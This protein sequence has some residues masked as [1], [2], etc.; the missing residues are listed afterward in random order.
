M[1]RGWVYLVFGPI[2]GVIGSLL[3]AI[4]HDGADAALRDPAE[5][6]FLAHAFGFFVSFLALMI[7]AGLARV[8]PIVVRAPLI[9]ATGAAF[10]F[11]CFAV[12]LGQAPPLQRFVLVGVVA[13]GSMGICSLL[14]NDY[15]P[16]R[17]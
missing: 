2:F 13:A 10:A 6:A 8:A 7:D 1:K 12:A 16:G 15:S 4:I 5:G 3:W 11:A 14:A 17:A 9:A